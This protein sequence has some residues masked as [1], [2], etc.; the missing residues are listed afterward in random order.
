MKKSIVIVLAA[1]LVC[2]CGSKETK[3]SEKT[4]ISPADTFPDNSAPVAANAP[5]DNPVEMSGH[6][7]IEDHMKE[8]E[9]VIAE[10]QKTLP[11]AK[12]KYMKG[13]GQGEAFFLTVNLREGKN[14][15]RVFVRVTKWKNEDIEGTIAND[16]MVLSGYKNGQPISFKESEVLDWT[17]TKPDGSEEGN[18]IGKYIDSRRGG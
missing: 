18:Y 17:I 5:A 11:D 9:P 4:E 15:E 2:S 7:K 8:L 6:D 12:K 10:A 16:I 1:T 14:V 3:G 13:L